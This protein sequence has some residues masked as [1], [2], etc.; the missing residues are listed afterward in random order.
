MNWDDVNARV[1]GLGLHL[2]GPVELAAL[3]AATDLPALATV[4]EAKGIRVPAGSGSVTPAKLEAAVRRVAGNRLALLARWCGGPRVAALAIVYEAEDRR[5]LRA[6]ARGAVEGAAPEAR[7]RGL[8]PTPTLPSRMLEELARLSTPGAIGTT[9]AIWGHGLAAPF[10]DVVG[11]ERPDLLALDL[12]LA[13]AFAE[14]AS[15][16]VS[17]TE[18]RLLPDLQLMIDFENVR[19]AL[20]LTDSSELRPTD[21]WI[22]GGQALSRAHF[23]STTKRATP[24]DRIEYLIKVLAPSPLAA[25]LQRESPDLRA[26][27]RAVFSWRRA[28]ARRLARLDPLGPMPTLQYVLSVRAELVQLQ[29]LIW[30]R[31][32]GAPSPDRTGEKVA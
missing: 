22:P 8:L 9:L 23:I 11:Q 20:V 17:R 4:L 27:D 14:R 29:R 28:E 3:A 1:R 30:G 16:Q 7:L 25:I 13:R 26:L 10:R 6:L 31:A 32:M 21:C 19:S 18:P 12:G 24:Q 2:L 5:S 15:A